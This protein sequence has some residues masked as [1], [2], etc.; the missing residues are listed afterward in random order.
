M[1][2]AGKA[3][4]LWVSL[5]FPAPPQ[6][7]PPTSAGHADLRLCSALSQ[8]QRAHCHPVHDLLQPGAGGTDGQ[9]VP[10]PID[11]GGR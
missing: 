11:L 10:L 7:S 3:V 6:C 2:G 5:S 4:G 9:V 1:D 8:H